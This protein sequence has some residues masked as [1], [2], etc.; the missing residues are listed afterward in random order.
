MS[1][2]I[3]LSAFKGARP[4]KSVLDSE[5][6][7]PIE[8]RRIGRIGRRQDGHRKFVFRSYNLIAE[9]DDADLVRDV[10]LDTGKAQTKLKKI[11]EQIVID[12][13]KA[14]ARADMMTKAEA[15]LSAAIEAAERHGP[16][17]PPAQGD[18]VEQRREFNEA[19]R[20][21]I[22][23]VALLR[24]ISVE[25]IKPALTLKHHE[26]AKFTTKHGVNP[27]WLLEGKG[28]VFINEPPNS[29]RSSADLAALVYTLPEAQ[30]RKIEAVVDLLL[31]ER[32]K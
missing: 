26:I 31:E 8:P 12:R 3:E 10:R 13:D 23:I 5:S 17:Q 28:R 16:E 21:R 15:K 1:N 25:E 27:E 11:R 29:S 22:N 32:R 7:A 2:V 4:P 24:D 19:M 30:Q 6:D 18:R 9:S 20:R 14:A